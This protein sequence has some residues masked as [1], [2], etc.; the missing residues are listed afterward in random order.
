V[1]DP[2]AVV[3]ELDSAGDLPAGFG[4]LL[5]SVPR[6]R[7]IPDRIWVGGEPI[8]GATEPA[9]WLAAV[10]GDNSIV[11]QFDDGQTCWPEVGRIPTSSASMPSVVV[12]MLAALGVSA[13][14]TVLEVGTGTGYNAA[15]LARLVGESGRV[16][17]VE[18][19]DAIAGVARES[20]DRAG[21]EW[22]RTIIDDGATAVG[23]AVDRVIATMSV[24]LGRVPYAWVAQTKPGGRIVTPVRAELASGPLVEFT[25]HGDG[26]ATGRTLPMGVGFMESRLQRT[27]EAPD[28]DWERDDTEESISTVAPRRVLEVPSPR[29]A[30]AVAVPSCRY[31]VEGELVWLSD[32]VSGA[33]ASVVPA[34][35]GRFLVRQ[36]GIRRLWDEVEAAYRWWCERGEP[37]ITEWR[38]TITPERQGIELA[39]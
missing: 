34:G 16:T 6:E 14:Q 17:T 5:E 22:V 24:H 23:G 21:F 15:L 20:L 37:F 38:W 31:G 32:P 19:D 11:T 7:F 9:R 26:T 28:Q 2:S 12:G 39:R 13:G 1:T 27:G 33:W 25:V 10:Y 35:H 36:T 30:V 3:E 29:W 4:P 8:D 18:V